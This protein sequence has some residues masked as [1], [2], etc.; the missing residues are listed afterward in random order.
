MIG[1]LLLA[2]SSWQ[3]T[4]LHVRESEIEQHQIGQR[5]AQRIRTRCGDVDVEPLTDQALPQ[6]FRDR[7]VVFDDEQPHLIRLARRTIV[8]AIYLPNL[9]LRLAFF[10]SRSVRPSYERLPVRESPCAEQD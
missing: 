6:R 7:R 8:I 2:R 4:P 9:C 1:T 10:A 5:G 3:T